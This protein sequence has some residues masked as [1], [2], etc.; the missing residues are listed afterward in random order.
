MKYILSFAMLTSLATAL[1]A[2]E[3][4]DLIT[5]KGLNVNSSLAQIMSVLGDCRADPEYINNFICGED[6][7]TSSGY[8]VNDNGDITHISF[9]CE[10]INGCEYSG[11][12][13]ARLLSESLSLSEPELVLSSN[14]DFGTMMDGPAG[15][16]LF[17]SSTLGFSVTIAAHNYRK[18]GLTLD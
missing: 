8:T 6:W 5:I 10:I 1:Y 9:S 4:A 7:K 11:R 17:V 14:P 12:D 2:D 18:P 15:D 16:R 13:L 3:D